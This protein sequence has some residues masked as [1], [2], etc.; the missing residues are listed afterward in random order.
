[1]SM[2]LRSSQYSAVEPFAVSS[3][4]SL[5]TS[6]GTEGVSTKKHASKSLLDREAALR[7]G[8]EELRCGQAKLQTAAHR[9]LEEKSK[10]K[11]RLETTERECDRKLQAMRDSLAMREADVQRA[12]D[13]L[14]KH[15]A[16]LDL[17]N[18]KA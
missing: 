4:T 9:L 5:T 14:Q 10:W 16:E 12:Q 11:H 18:E 13:E 2:L 6:K 15:Q 1:M 7:C 8:E 3:A 17:Q